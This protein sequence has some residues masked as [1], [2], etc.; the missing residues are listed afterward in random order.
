MSARKDRQERRAERIA[1]ES[2][3][4]ASDRRRRALRLAAGAAFLAL[5]AVVVLIVAG[6]RS[7]RG[8]DPTHVV[9]AGAVD[10][11]LARS[12][13]R[14]LTIGRADAPVHLF[15]YGDLQCPFCRA[16]S[17]AEIPAVIEGPVDAGKAKITFRNLLIIGPESLPAGA[18]AIAAG[19]QGRG[20][21]YVETFYRNQGEENSGYVTEDFL[22]AVARAAGIKDMATWNKR[23]RSKAVREEATR[24]T[25]SAEGRFGF[26]ATPSF[27]IEGPKTDGLELLGTP[28]STRQLEEAIARAA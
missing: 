25:E 22:E 9:E 3:T 11:L 7:G 1:A 2:E 16:F 17:E 18:A 5:I 27:A 26:H 4:A 10:A 12:P 8:G 15:E 24:T 14:R 28:E 21:N 23:R 19:E 20:W 13:Q 6:S